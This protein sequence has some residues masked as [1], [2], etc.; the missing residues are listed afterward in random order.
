MPGFVTALFA[1]AF[2]CGAATIA[3]PSQSEVTRAGEI[4]VHLQG[5]G[6]RLLRCETG[7]VRSLERQPG[8][9]ADPFEV[10]LSCVGDLIARVTDDGSIALL[11]G[12]DFAPVGS[13]RIVTA[14][15]AIGSVVP[16][17]LIVE[18]AEE[19]S[20]PRMRVH[21]AVDRQRN[22]RP[23]QIVLDVTL[24]T[25]GKSGPRSGTRFRS[26]DMGIVGSVEGAAPASAATTAYG[27]DDR[28]AALLIPP[29]NDACLGAITIPN[30]TLPV[31][32]AVTD[33]AD[34]TTLLDPVTCV[35]V[36]RTV[37]YAFTA[38][39]TGTYT[40]ST[41]WSGG[42]IGT[43]LPDT[44]L[45]LYEEGLG[46]AAIGPIV[47]CNDDDS[48]CSPSMPGRSN[49]PS[50]KQ[51]TLSAAL[52][53]GVRY[54]VVV[55][56][57]AGVGETLVTTGLTSVQ[58]RVAANLPPAND[59]CAGAI[60]LQLDRPQTGSTQFATNDYQLSTSFPTCYTLPG[61]PQP[62]GQLS[63]SVAPGRDSVYR[64]LAP[65]AG[66]Y[67]F[68]VTGYAS[69]QN[70]I[71]YVTPSCP[72]VPPSPA[73]IANP[74]C[75][76]A[77]NR[78]ST[79]GAE[80][81]MWVQLAA[82][83]QVFIVVDDASGTN[84]GSVFKI[85]VNRTVR[86][87]EPNGTT[88]S[89]NTIGCPITGSVNPAGE[90]DFYTLGTP[91][92]GRRV[93]A[94]SD[95][96]AENDTDQ[97]MRLTT[98]TDTVEFDD[99]ANFAPL[100]SLSPAIAGRA[101]TGTASYLRLNNFTAS[102]TAEPYR[103]YAVVQPAIGS[104]S[105]ETEPNG[106][107]LLA[108]TAP[109]NY[110]TGSL[111]GPAPSTDVDVYK[112]VARAGELIVLG[113]D[114]DP[115][116]NATPIDGALELTDGAGNTLVWA[117]D[118]GTSGNSSS[119]TSGA[120][121]L[122]ATTPYS[123]GESIV[124]RAPATDTY[125]ARVQIG[126]TSTTAIGA[127]DYLLSIGL[128]CAIADTDAD[129]VPDGGDCAPSD[130]TLWSAAGDPSSLLLSGAS[131]TTLTWSA[132]P[133]PGSTSDLYDVLRSSSRSDFSAASATCLATVLTVTSTIDTGAAPAP[134]ASWFYLVRGR[135]SCGSNMG[136]NS[137]GVART[138]RTCP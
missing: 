87:T 76:G 19:A 68:R 69:S 108:N 77:A 138:G 122:T 22:A 99:D 28:T 70:P 110:F 58:V 8:E 67:S 94:T 18:E 121:S 132:S 130:Q 53:G 14:S 55:G 125:Y 136:T 85:E 1:L 117:N 57:Y 23:V 103:L 90:V 41:C 129:G 17:K 21:L 109:S 27:F 137:A 60:P 5:S 75:L 81:V 84:A 2:G 45:A 11:A 3:A 82:G 64:F 104:A 9:A 88:A 135:N 54:F 39:A 102:A 20:G 127:G 10:A 86:E 133:D 98:T 43:S 42:A 34:A 89:A 65:S 79:Q 115:L 7:P 80:E 111:A 63:T 46:C 25:D 78:N 83:Q 51:S 74:P 31:L 36:D 29:T 119:T 59:T 56:R 47:L 123:P 35:T 71:L 66:R 131:P 112:F 40:F 116:R 106:S 12:S 61:P 93:F 33:L 49:V 95:G 50:G 32:S 113:F 114:G 38:P 52:T 120:G 134:G 6:A 37:W 128:N 100:G 97:Q 107:L 44:V 4:S 13:V 72:Q 124:F 24:V 62:I 26:D 118:A 96:V 92:S 16:A 73:T 105:A 126:T 30:T 91:T 101:V 15:D 48:L